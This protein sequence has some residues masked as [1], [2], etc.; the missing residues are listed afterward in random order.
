MKNCFFGRWSGLR[1][2]AA[3]S[4]VASRGS[5]NFFGY[6]FL[7]RDPIFELKSI[8]GTVR[9]L[10]NS[11]PEKLN[12]VPKKILQAAKLLGPASIANCYLPD[13]I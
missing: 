9:S 13:W 8:I 2:F 7:H 10:G 6:T 4:E 12:L 3:R 11:V 5:L 1:F